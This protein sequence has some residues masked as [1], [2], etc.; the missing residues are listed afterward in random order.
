MATT[1]A[2]GIGT[3]LYVSNALP[4]TENQAGYEALTWTAVGEVTELPEHGPSHEV[5]THVPLATGITQ[6][7]HGVKNNGSMAVPYAVDRDDAGQVIVNT[8]LT[9]RNRASFKIEW[10]DN[11]GGTGTAD[12]FQGKVMSATRGA[13]SG[14]ASAGNMQIEIETDF[15]TV[16]AS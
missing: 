4:A 5:V 12:Y 6:K 15:V 10:P 3:K 9:T 11:P 2:P 8:I 1:I 7:F 16:A 13:S 14:A